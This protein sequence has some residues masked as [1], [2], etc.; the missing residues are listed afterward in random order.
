MIILVRSA[1]QAKIKEC[2]VIFSRINSAFMGRCTFIPYILFK[3][4]MI[5]IIS[6]LKKGTKLIE[7]KFLR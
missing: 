4:F 1:K 6:F 2:K 3:S 7:N 5:Q